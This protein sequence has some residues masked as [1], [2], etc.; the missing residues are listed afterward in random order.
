MSRTLGFR[1]ERVPHRPFPLLSSRHDLPIEGYPGSETGDFAGPIRA[2]T[3]MPDDP[4]AQ[5]C[6]VTHRFSAILGASGGG[7]LSGSSP[8]WTFVEE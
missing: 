5:K 6:G 4:I 7:A 3:G 8:L 2:R 1:D